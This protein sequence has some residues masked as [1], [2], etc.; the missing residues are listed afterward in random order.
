MRTLRLGGLVLC[1]WLA[2][3]SSNASA[4]GAADTVRT[5]YSTLMN[6]MQNGSRL[7]PSGRYNQMAAIVPRV[8]DVPYMSRLAVGPQWDSLSDAERRQISDAFVRYI[9]ATYAERFDKYEGEQL[10][11]Q[12]E[13]GAAGGTMV[14]SQIIKS[15]GEPVHINYLMHQSGGGWVIADVYLN[16]TISEL[17]T[18]RSEFGSILR[19]QGVPGLIA[20]LNNKA[21]V[22]ARSG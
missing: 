5:L 14:T 4:A 11:V 22:L 17:A 16:G 3:V 9:A 18:R 19:S 20:A 21:A 10:Q 8:F 7:G 15:N 12:G 6:I 2:L 1:A 13:Q